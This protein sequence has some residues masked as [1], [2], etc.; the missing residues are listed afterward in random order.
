M[1]TAA[2]MDA[3]VQ[4]YLDTGLRSLGTNTTPRGVGIPGAV[5]GLLD[6]QAK[7][8]KLDRATVMAPAIRLARD[9]FTVTP[10]LS[11]TIASSRAKLLEEPAA[12]AMPEREA[13]RRRPGLGR[14]EVAIVV[15]AAVAE[16]DPARPEAD[17]RDEEEAR[18]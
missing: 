2:S 4:D 5:R 6:A 11:R 15:A 17:A 10:L 3:D 7:Y 18:L 16:P 1:T 8:G 14:R 12:A 13:E 9:G